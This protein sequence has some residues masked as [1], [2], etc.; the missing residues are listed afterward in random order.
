MAPV[1][2]KQYRFSP[3]SIVELRKKLGLSQAGLARALGVPSNTVSRWENDATTPDAASLAA[4]H[5]VAMERGITPSFFKKRKK[6]PMKRTRLLVVW[7]FPNLAAHVQH[8]P[9]IDT[10]LRAECD[11]RFPATNQRTFKAFVGATSGFGQFDPADT[12]LDRGWK[13]WEEEEDEDLDETI[14]D[15]CKSDCGQDPLST[16]LVLVTRD[17]EYAEMIEELKG[18]GVRVYL[19]GFGCSQELATAVGEK[20]LIELP[21]PSN[22]A[23]IISNQSHHPWLQ[24]RVTGWY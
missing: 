24:H 20:R 1:K 16:T 3:E 11:K 4:I 9:D 2:Q 21:W 13:V 6:Q 22:F 10:W 14:I 12:L 15:H 5:S 8:V 23:R 17:G 19:I 7:D 18:Q